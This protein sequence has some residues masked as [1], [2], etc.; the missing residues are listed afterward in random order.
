[1]DELA[2]ITQ[3]YHNAPTILFKKINKV[4]ASPR[5]TE[6]FILRA[7]QL[8]SS[9][10][11]YIGGT[12]PAGN[13]SQICWVSFVLRTTYSIKIEREI[14]LKVQKCRWFAFQHSP[15]T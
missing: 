12:Q 15:I 9:A 7:F 11:N 14:P 10:V 3:K 8:L 2:A 1:M 13:G 4:A 5:N 6:L